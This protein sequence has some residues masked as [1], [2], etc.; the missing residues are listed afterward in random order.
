[1]LKR[2]ALRKTALLAGSGLMLWVGA[3]LI[4]PQPSGAAQKSSYTIGVDADFSGPFAFY[5]TVLKQAWGA[6]F[7]QVNRAGGISGHPVKV[8]YLDNTSVPTTIVADAK[9]LLGDNALMV[10]SD[11]DS[12]SCSN[13]Y[14]LTKAANVPLMCEAVA[15]AQLAPPLGGMYSTDASESMYIPSVYKDITHRTNSHPKIAEM[16]VDVVGETGWANSMTKV[17]AANG[18]KVVTDQLI[19]VTNLTNITSQTAAVLAS[20][21]DAVLTEVPPATTISFVNALRQGGFKGPIYGLT[22]DYGSMVALK[23]PAFFQTWAGTPVQSASGGS[24]AATYIKSLAAVGVKGVTNINSG[25]MSQDYLSAQVIVAALK[26]CGNKCTASS[27]NA[28]LT[29]TTV[30]LP[31]VTLPTGYGYSSSRHQPLSKFGLYAWSSSKKTV[32]QSS[33]LPVS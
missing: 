15:L 3:V 31:G 13:I 25:T 27:F 11:P 18:G 30:N 14:P 24:G 23:D 5:G 33:L 17:A 32:V 20:N 8:I 9:E 7:G 16:I 6:V 28:A 4:M 10:R 29:K 21:P 26:T 12:D 1:M 2:T 22:P 19:P